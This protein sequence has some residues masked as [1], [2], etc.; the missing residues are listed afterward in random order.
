[1]T[2][3]RVEVVQAVVFVVHAVV[4]AIWPT[5]IEAIFEKVR[6]PGRE[7]WSGQLLVCSGSSQSRPRCWPDAIVGGSS[8]PDPSHQ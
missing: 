5:W 2:R 4:T 7:R 6:T 1:M 8:V 3:V